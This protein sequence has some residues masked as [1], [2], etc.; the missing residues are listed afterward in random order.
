[1][2]DRTPKLDPIWMAALGFALVDKANISHLYWSNAK[3]QAQCRDDALPN[4]VVRI[5]S[6]ALEHKTI[7]TSQIALREALL[8]AMGL[9]EHIEYDDDG[10][11]GY[12]KRTYIRRED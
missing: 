9:E 8:P 3:L 4:D 7:R 10:D 6:A 12:T 5:Y 2:T 11:G 1:M